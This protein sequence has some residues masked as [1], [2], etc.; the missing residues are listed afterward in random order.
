MT[1]ELLT[2]VFDKAAMIRSVVRTHSQ[3][4]DSELDPTAL[5]QEDLGIDSIM[6]AMIVADLN[7]IF[8]PARLLRTDEFDTLDSLIRKFSCLDLPDEPKAPA[9]AETDDSRI[10]LRDF[11]NEVTQSET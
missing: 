9:A 5:L 3:Y 7:R 2:P 4:D 11:V 10:T 6:L 8:A 1:E